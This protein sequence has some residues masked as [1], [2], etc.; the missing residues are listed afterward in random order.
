MKKGMF[1]FVVFFNQGLTDEMRA[2]FRLMKAMADHTLQ[3]PEQ[4]TLKIYD[5]MVKLLR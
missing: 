1:C 3:P 4:R 2:N 5:F